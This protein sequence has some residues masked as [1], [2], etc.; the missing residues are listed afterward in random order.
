MSKDPNWL[1]LSQVAQLL[2]VHSS[3][4]RLWAD[5]GDLPAHRTAGKHRRFRRAEVE[6]WAAARREAQPPAGQMIV[7]A[8]LGRTRLQMTEGRLKDQ[9][10]YAKLD[11]ARRAEFREAGRRL[12]SA[13]LRYLNEEEPEAATAAAQAVGRDYARLGRAAGLTLAETV[14]LFQFF[15][16]FLYDSVV[17]VYQAQGRRAAR[18]WATMH[19]RVTAF[20]KA[21]MLALVEAHPKT[22]APSA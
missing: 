12:L 20:T 19:R 11:E 10:W 16:D 15:D 2:G 9:N 3:T 7:Q 4:V 21:V 22:E 18:E 17:D 13:L 5:K 8:A 1:S 6:A 14:R